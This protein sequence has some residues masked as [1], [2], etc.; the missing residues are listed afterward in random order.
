MFLFSNVCLKK[1]KKYFKIFPDLKVV[2][3][4]LKC[5]ISFLPINYKGN[6]LKKSAPSYF[7]Y[8]YYVINLIEYDYGILILL[9]NIIAL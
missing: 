4:N 5:F 9:Y 7:Q 8:N 2:T 6:S 1:N 3:I